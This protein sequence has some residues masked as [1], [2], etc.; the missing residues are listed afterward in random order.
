MH[1][2]VGEGLEEVVTIQYQTVGLERVLSS[3]NDTG[4]K[5]LEMAPWIH[6]S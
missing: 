6:N 2:G 3:E 1:F 4:R 5:G